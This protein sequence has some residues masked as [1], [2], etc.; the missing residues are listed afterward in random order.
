MPRSSSESVSAIQDVAAQQ[1]PATAKV[2]PS[3]GARK[4]RARVATTAASRKPRARKTPQPTAPVQHAVRAVEIPLVAEPAASSP[5]P[6][7]QARQTP[8]APAA[9]AQLLTH[10]LAF[11]RGPGRAALLVALKTIWLLLKGTGTLVAKLAAF[12]VKATGILLAKARAWVEA[13]RRREDQ[14]PLLPPLEAFEGSEE[15]DDGDRRYQIIDPALA[16][17]PGG[18]IPPH[19]RHVHARV[20]NS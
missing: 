3:A 2:V 14:E 6:P 1:G 19:Q 8:P 17:Q 16:F 20:N 9:R 13:V 12:A 11:A 4:T 15:P 5:A 7:V 10:V 18:R